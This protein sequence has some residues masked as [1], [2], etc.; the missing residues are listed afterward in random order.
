MSPEELTLPMPWGHIAA[1][2][3][4]SPKDTK[5]LVVHG[6]LDNSGSF[7]RLIQLL[8]G[9]YYFVCIDLPGHGLSSHFPAGIP[10]D[11]FN[12]VLA[13]RRVLDHLKWETCLYIG[14]SLGGSVGMMFASIYPDR[15]IRI[16]IFDMLTAVPIPNDYL[17]SRIRN[18]HDNTLNAEV[19]SSSK[20]YTRDEVM[21]SL[22]NLRFNTLSVE[23]AEALMKRSVTKVGD[24]FKYNRDRRL[25]FNVIPL[26]NVD[27]HLT[28][29]KHLRIPVSIVLSS[30]TSDWTNRNDFKRILMEMTDRKNFFVC[31]INGNHDFHNNF[32]ERAEPH[33]R[34]FL[35][36]TK[37]SL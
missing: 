4:G 20:L 34:R 21:H 35:T 36:W 18:A 29:L 12:Y 10:L 23:A 6:I 14:H 13:I 11:Y 28:I 15:L 27:Q 1:Q 26:L 9:G 30:T 3:W 7:D 2:A 32:P 8:P 17:V 22:M 33:V 24:K 25:N 19:D 31:T 16:L 37:S 5:V